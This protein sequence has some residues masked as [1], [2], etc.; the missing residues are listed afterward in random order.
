MVFNNRNI[1]DILFADFKISLIK[2][3]KKNI[4]C[5]KKIYV[6]ELNFLNS[7]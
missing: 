1:V 3:F 5:L 2:F 7:Q 6:V 4:I